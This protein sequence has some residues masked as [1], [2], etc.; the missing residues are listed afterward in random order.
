MIKKPSVDFN[1]E[2]LFT[3]SPTP[4]IVIKTDAPKYTVICVNKAYLA[5]SKSRKKYINDEP[6]F[7]QSIGNLW[8]SNPKCTKIL[9]DSFELVVREKKSKDIKHLKVTIPSEIKSKQN[10]QYWD[11]NNTPILNSDGNVELI[12]ISINDITGRYLCHLENELMLENTDENFILVDLDLNIVNF[13]SQFAKNYKDVFGIEVI[14]GD[15]ILKYASPERREIVKGIY[16]KSFQGGTT[17]AEMSFTFKGGAEKFFH[18][19]YKPAFDSN[20]EIVGAFVT[21]IDITESRQF[22]NQ[23]DK[24]AFFTLLKTEIF[25]SMNESDEL[26]ICLAKILK[27]MASVDAYEYAEAWL[28][29]I[30]RT[31]LNH[32]SYW[33]SAPKYQ[34][35][36]TSL[37]QSDFETLGSVNGLPSKTW[38]TMKSQVW[39]NLKEHPEFVRKKIAKKTKIESAIS[40]PINDANKLV[41]VFIFFSK[42]NEP[43]SSKLIEVF[44]H[45]NEQI[46]AELKR[47]TAEETIKRYFD[48]SPDIIC[49][50][51]VDGYFKKVN[52]AFCRMMGYSEQELLETPYMNFIHPASQKSTEDQIIRQQT[53]ER[54]ESFINQYVSKKGELI[55]LSWT[56]TSIVEEGI[57]IAVAKNITAS[58]ELEIQLEKTYKQARIGVWEVNLM[59]ETVVWSQVTRE[60]H[61]VDDDFIPN[62]DNAISFYKEGWSRDRIQNAVVHLLKTGERFAEELLIITAKGNERWIRTIGEAAFENGKCIRFFGSFQDIHAKKTAEIQI[63]QLNEELIKQTN[64]LKRSNEELESFAYIASHDLQE[65]LRMVTSFLA[66]LEKKYDDILDERGKRYIFY[67]MDGAKRMRQ[68]ILDLLEFS[69]VGR[70]ETQIEKINISDIIDNIIILNRKIIDELNADIFVNK[71]PTIL[72][73]KIGIQQIFQ[74]LI[75]NSLKYRRKDVNPIIKI[76]YKDLGT[77]WQFSVSDNGIGINADYFDKIFIIF[78]RLHARDEYSGSGVGL[79]ICKKIIENFGGEIWVES[80]ENKGSTFYFTINKI[81]AS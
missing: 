36:S 61:E 73:S 38:K 63:N 5:L 37:T 1:Y 39:H 77:H 47:K 3:V 31:R 44:K 28:P 58:K 42:N 68:I 30:D 67:A 9:S 53:G 34:I 16:N 79:A 70:I 29:N 35:F 19:S 49:I 24:E 59:D 40:I 55:W 17:E 12:F 72:G 7:S 11:V 75:N 78:Q 32:R 23:R 26:D 57:M 74:N 41:G 46:A 8:V 33:S 2:N 22:E 43:D 13:N 62:Y 25:E 76:S 14:K 52:Q 20:R 4:G 48:L 69:R 56:A 51:G 54:T 15:S 80:E 64:E 60:I 71:M 10:V 27:K 45:L 81:I 18:F 21:M 6:F 50:V 65:P 66:Q